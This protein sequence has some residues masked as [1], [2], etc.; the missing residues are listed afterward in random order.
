MRIAIW[1]NLNSGGAKRFLY[2][3]V[4]GLIERGH[5]VESWC[6]S[7]VDQTYL[8]MSD[9]VK[10][11]ILPLSWR[12]RG[13]KER[14]LRNLFPARRATDPLWAITKHCE[15]CAR[16]IDA[17]GF[18]LLMAHSCVQ[19]AVSPIGRYIKSMPKVLFLQEPRRKLYEAQPEL[20]WIAMRSPRRLREYLLYPAAFAR[21]LM[22]VQGVRVQARE[23]LLNARAYDLVL[24]NSVFSRESLA[25]AYAIDS[26]VCCPGIDTDFFRPTSSPRGHFVVGLGAMDFTKGLDRAVRAIATIPE[27]DRPELVWIGN[28][29]V[30]RYT[31]EVEALASSLGVKLTLRS[32]ISDEEL[33][34]TLSR[35]SAMVYMSR[36]EPYGLAPLEANACGTPV[37]AIAEGGV[38][39]TI[40][41][42]V[43]GIL[44]QWD[45]P[46]AIGTAISRL[47]DNPDLAA[48]MG[49]R[50]REHVIEHRSWKSCMDQL[51]TY[52]ECAKD[53]PLQ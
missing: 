42:G 48:E 46:Q 7:T 1:H 40:V 45:D 51:E 28:V 19:L 8:P 31:K 10:E 35:A 30:S 49:A 20:P 5:Y 24:A 3:T 47:L 4:R 13:F 36:L 12:E 34:D 29:V 27:A 39:E 23:E 52:L 53:I 22:R 50:A 18:D 17:G 9:I 43:N 15:E 37:V 11:N 14:M 2:T 33:L 21:D 32:R 41:D 6:P 25:R 38:R 26:R 44:V 16:Q